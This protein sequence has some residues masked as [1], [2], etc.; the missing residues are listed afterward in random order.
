MLKNSIPI[1]K[2]QYANSHSYVQLILDYPLER[3]R[4]DVLRYVKSYLS[5]SCSFLSFFLPSMHILGMHTLRIIIVLDYILY[6]HES[7]MLE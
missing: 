7:L 5:A 4:A 2:E 1:Q 6:V 3:K